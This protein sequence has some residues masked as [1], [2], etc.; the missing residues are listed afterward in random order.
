MAVSDVIQ[1]RLAF[2]TQSALRDLNG[3][4]PDLRRLNHVDWFYNNVWRDPELVRLHWLPRITRIVEQAAQRGGRVLEIGCG[5]GFLA[6]ELAR[7]G[8]HVTAVDISD[9]SIDIADRTLAQN[10][11][12]ASFGSLHYVCTDASCMELAPAHFETVV[13]FR[14]LHHFP[15]AGNMLARIH[16]WL[17]PGGLLLLS[18]PIRARFSALS[19]N[20]AGL[21]RAL[22]PT[23]IAFDE[24]LNIH[25]TIGWESYI[26]QIH[27]EYTREHEHRQSPND[28]SIDDDAT[29]LALLDKNF[30]ITTLQ[31]SDAIVDKLIGGLR[32][33]QRLAMAG[34]LKTVDDYL[35][36]QALLPPTSVEIEAV[37]V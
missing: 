35:V 33:P 2:N 34:L 13:C 14:S 3:F 12:S 20:I 29:L 9:T 28:N 27:D 17:R 18:E 11:Y 24:K 32:G 15:D 30:S 16:Q 22:L 4:I 19:A 25:D 26:Q 8:L 36:R 6:L 21:L 7:A 5:N 37:K 10:T 23:W 1:E 31:Y